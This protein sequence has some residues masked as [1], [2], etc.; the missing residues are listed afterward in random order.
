MPAAAP[1]LADTLSDRT[2]SVSVFKVPEGWWFVAIRNDLILPEDD[3]LY[4]DEEDAKKTFFSMMAV[5][6]WGRKIAPAEWGVEGTEEAD[7]EGILRR[8]KTAKLQKVGSA[9]GKKIAI[10]GAVLLGAVLIAVFYL[11]S[12]LFTSAPAPQPVIT[13]IAKPKAEPPPPPPPPPWEDLADP[14]DIVNDCADRVAKARSFAIPGWELTSAACNA[15]AMTSNWTAA[16][17]RIAWFGK[18]FDDLK[19]GTSFRKSMGEDGRNASISSDFSKVRRLNAAPAYSITELKHE[20]TDIFNSVAT[21]VQ[22]GVETEGQT[23]DP[24]NPN[25][26]PRPAYRYMK[27]SFTST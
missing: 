17:G 25:A 3:V 15:F 21:S 14:S 27:F 2:S 7:L 5:P 8:G 9:H 10:V 24:V 19:L 26:P 1:A 18:G 20:L 16:F 23:A 12:S 6:D 4:K 11:L 22:L 13:P